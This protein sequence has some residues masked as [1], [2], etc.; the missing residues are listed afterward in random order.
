MKKNKKIS[1]TLLV[2]G[3]KGFIGSNFIKHYTKKKNFK[4]ISFSHKKL[5]IL[6]KTSLKNVILKYRPDFIINFAAHRD[7]NTAE[8][9]RGDVSGSAWKT[10]YIGVK[11][12]LEMSQKYGIFLIHISTDMVFP[13]IKEY[14]GPY[15]EKDVPELNLFNLSWYGWTKANAEQLLMGKKLTAIIRIGNVTQPIYDPKLD[16]IGKIKF[17]FDKNMLY[18]M[19]KNQFLTLTYV[20]EIFNTIDKIIE[21]KVEGVFHVAS[22]DLFTPKKLAAYLLKKLNKKSN[23]VGIDIVK[24]L[25]NV[26]NRYPQYGGLRARETEKKLGIEF[27][28]WK[29]IVN[30][31]ISKT[32]TRK[33]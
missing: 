6:N 12:L 18:P 24:Y 26:P 23:V 7:A 15:R 1:N 27:M 8:F 31:Y 28:T 11:N 29:E 16:Y 10:N 13:G 17:L 4:I 32:S 2:T 25:E 5:D 22:K 14:K 21:K 30:K 9:Q 19:F 20:P 33:K 3:G